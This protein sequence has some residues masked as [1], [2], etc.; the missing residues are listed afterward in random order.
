[1]TYEITLIDKYGEEYTASFVDAEDIYEEIDRLNAYLED[2]SGAAYS[3]ISRNIIE[4][5]DFLS[6]I[7][8]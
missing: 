1:M 8:Q 5:E 3:R 4:L 2:V 7:E 6:S